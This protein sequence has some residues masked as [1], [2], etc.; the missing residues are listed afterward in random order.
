M[1]LHEGRA[2]RR[3]FPVDYMGTYTDSGGSRSQIH[4]SKVVRLLDLYILGRKERSDLR[5]VSHPLNPLLTWD[6]TLYLIYVSQL[7]MD[8]LGQVT[9]QGDRTLI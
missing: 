1:E 6:A 9:K 8:I 4:Y 3:L 2:K 5:L 7:S